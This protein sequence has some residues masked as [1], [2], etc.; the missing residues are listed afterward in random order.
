M[1]DGYDD[2]ACVLV[3]SDLRPSTY[4]ILARY[5]KERHV[6]VGE[7]LSL[8]ADRAVSK[9]KPKPPQKRK[10][11]RVEDDLDREIRRLNAEDRN[12]T[13]IADEIGLS[14]VSVWRR[15]KNLGLLSPRERAL[16]AQS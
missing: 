14:M 12:D 1:T 11:E 7:V 15:R 3:R 4:R 2:G 10:A 13:Q 6:E 8:L 16:A 9:P 5:A